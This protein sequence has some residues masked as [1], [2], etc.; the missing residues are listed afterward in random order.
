MRIYALCRQ[1]SSEVPKAY[2]APSSEGSNISIETSF[3]PNDW[4]K[5]PEEEKK[6]QSLGTGI[7]PVKAL[8]YL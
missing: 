6:D 8:P 4:T 1:Y 3:F 2:Q 7:F 5:F